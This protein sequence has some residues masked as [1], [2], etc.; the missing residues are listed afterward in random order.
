MTH[1]LVILTLVSLA[2][3]VYT[4]V[5]YPIAVAI[6]GKLFPL[7]PTIDPAWLPKV[8]ALIPVYNAASYVRAKLDSLL[9]QDYPEDELEILIYSDGSTDESAAIVKEYAARDPRVRLVDG[10]PRKGKP[11]ALNVMRQSATGEVFLMTDIRQPLAPGALRALVSRLSDP[12]VACVSGNLILRGTTGA[13]VYWKY[14]NWIRNSEARFRSMVGVTGPIYVIRRED[15]D[16][17]PLD[18]I[19]DDQW[20]PMRLRLARRKLL[21]CLEAEAYD[22]AFADEREFG[23]KVR[24]L[25]GNYQ[26]FAR[27]PRLLVPLAN[28]SWFETFSHKILRLVGPW[29]LAVLFVASGI[30]AFLPAAQVGGAGWSIVQRSLFGCQVLFY[31]AATLGETAGRVSAVARSFVVLNAAAVVGLWR[32]ITGRQKVTW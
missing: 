13:G 11:N 17:L 6:L 25:A 14:E 3:L 20:I 32:W 23:R 24:T 26:L 8:T 15:L 27:L 12:R 16:P 21:L 30:S 4:Y 1:P 18:I 7:R 31:L 10:G 28:P 29:A 9:A 22:E 5:G 2:L 19:L